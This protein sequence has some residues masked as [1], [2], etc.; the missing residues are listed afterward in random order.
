MNFLE[1]KKNLIIEIKIRKSEYNLVFYI[2]YSTID[3]EFKETS[4]SI[5]H[6]LDHMEKGLDFYKQYFND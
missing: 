5:N 6:E 2:N 3:K 4:K 1:T